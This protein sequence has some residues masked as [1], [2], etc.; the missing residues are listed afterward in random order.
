[1]SQPVVTRTY[2][3]SVNNRST[4]TSLNQVMGDYLFTIKNFLV[5]TLGYAVKYSCDG[6]TGPTSGADHTDRWTTAA[7]ARTRGATTAAASSWIVL[8][9]GD[10]VDF[11]LAYVGST[12][13]VGRY[14]FSQT[15]VFTPAGTATFP[16]TAAD[17]VIA[18][19]TGSW[20]EP[21]TSLD[22]II[23][24]M[25]TADKKNWR[26]LIS[27][28]NI[29]TGAFLG[30]ETYTSTL[31]APA[32]QAVNK[33]AIFQLASNT[34]TSSLIMSGGAF[35]FARI[36]LSSVATTVN[37]LNG[38]ED[39]ST[40]QGHFD[41]V[42]AELQGANGPIARALSMMSNAGKLGN[43]I[44]WWHDCNQVAAGQTTTDKKLIHI[45][46]STGNVGGLLWPWD[47]TSTPVL[48]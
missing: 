48:S 23:H 27:R 29:F 10:G 7:N 3:F 37:W 21:T 1:M 17:E 8:T 35:G 46:N 47:G 43:L 16:A 28:N 34:V 39:Y 42:N 38:V 6:T 14:S 19:I 33:T 32:V 11:M 30:L 2:T 9:D 45:T 12:D 15:A 4:Y 24:V 18:S 40:S 41:G 13:D 20:I 26:A 22:R 5:A 44:D 36:V 25:G 31:V